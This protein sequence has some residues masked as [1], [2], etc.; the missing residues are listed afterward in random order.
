MKM[1]VQL[2]LAIIA[3]AAA[4]LISTIARAKPDTKKYRS[5]P[6][7]TTKRSKKDMCSKKALEIY[8]SM[9]LQV[10]IDGTD[11]GEGEGEDNNGMQLKLSV[12]ELLK[13]HCEKKSK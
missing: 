10:P 8:R 13:Q 1:K 9:Y 4:L 5:G 2:V 6:S 12:Y 3:L 11:S 7:T